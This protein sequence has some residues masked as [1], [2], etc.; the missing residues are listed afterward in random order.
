MG[1]RSIEA[2]AQVTFSGE[3]IFHS[4][5]IES[6]SGSMVSHPPDLGLV[7][8]MV[9]FVL[10][11]SLCMMRYEENNMKWFKHGNT[12]FDHYGNHAMSLSYILISQKHI[13][14]VSMHQNIMKM[15]IWISW[16]NQ[17]SM[18]YSTSLRLFGSSKLIHTYYIA[19]LEFIGTTSWSWER[20]QIGFASCPRFENFGIF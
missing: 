3:L 8:S 17:K 12:R 1:W 13:S 16:K 15:T 11:N 2:L 14:N 19:L 7:N 9:A 5:K 10:A 18:M 20:M 4:C 6:I